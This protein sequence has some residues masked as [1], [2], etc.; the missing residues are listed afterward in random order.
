MADPQSP[1][2]TA[3]TWLLPTQILHT[4]TPMIPV[5]SDVLMIWSHN[6]GLSC[7]KQASKK[8]RREDRHTDQQTHSCMLVCCSVSNQLLQWQTHEQTGRQKLPLT[9]MGK[10]AGQEIEG[11]APGVSVPKLIQEL[12][13][14]RWLAQPFFIFIGPL[15][16]HPGSQA[17]THLHSLFTYS[18]SFIKSSVSMPNCPSLPPLTH[19]FGHACTHAQTYSPT[20]PPTSFL[21]SF[22]QPQHLVQWCWYPAGCQVQQSRTSAHQHWQGKQKIVHLLSFSRQ[23]QSNIEGT[24][25][26]TGF[27]QTS[28]A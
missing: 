28:Q 14:L 26:C 27:G 24:R 13:H 22:M 18:Y 4:V 10:G 8:Q 11:Q 12:S 23:R 3:Q 17:C 15:S 2:A 20:Y 25:T 21:C 19:S 16:L 6:C 7:N 1:H 9:Q 5:S